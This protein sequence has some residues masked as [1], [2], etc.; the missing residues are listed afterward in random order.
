M[1]V[2]SMRQKLQNLLADPVAGSAVRRELLGPQTGLQHD[3]K[4]AAAR[5]YAS[6]IRAARRAGNDAFD[7][8]V[9]IRM[10]HRDF[11]AYKL[12]ELL[13]LVE[14]LM[15]RGH[16]VDGATL[17]WMALEEVVNESI[18]DHDGSNF[19]LQGSEADC[20]WLHEQVDDLATRILV[21]I[22]R[23]HSTWRSKGHFTEVIKGWQVKAEDEH[24][25]CTYRYQWSMHFLET[26]EIEFSEDDGHDGA[27]DAEEELNSNEDLDADSRT[28]GW[29]SERRICDVEAWLENDKS[30]ILVKSY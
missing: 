6:I 4:E 7:R 27:V 20:D 3:A 11:W 14:A 28:G 25:F 2:E 30:Q 5:E 21:D 24:G 18:C 19:R 9:E 10:E 16:L 22:M 8:A 26:G 29:L 23:Y 1:S 12:K 17:A 13:P 15:T